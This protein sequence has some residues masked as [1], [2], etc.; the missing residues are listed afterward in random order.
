M[1]PLSV[2]AIMIMSI[3]RIPNLQSATHFVPKES[4]RTL[5]DLDYNWISHCRT[6]NLQKKEFGIL[7]SSVSIESPRISPQIITTFTQLFGEHYPEGRLLASEAI[8]RYHPPLIPVY[9]SPPLICSE[10]T[11]V[12]FSS[13]SPGIA[14]S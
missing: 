11:T 13:A 7:K 5:M 8:I 6:R 4:I 12:H 10:D 3:R 2:I 9:C 14:I 1:K